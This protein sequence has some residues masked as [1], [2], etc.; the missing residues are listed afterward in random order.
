MPGIGLE[1]AYT[2]EAPKVGFGRKAIK[3]DR[4]P[5]FCLWLSATVRRIANYVGLGSS[6]GNAVLALTPRDCL[7]Q[8]PN[9]QSLRRVV[10]AVVRSCQFEC[11]V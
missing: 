2:T 6:C 10:N 4:S 1:P 3:R 5:I 7:G 11:F 8:L 9:V